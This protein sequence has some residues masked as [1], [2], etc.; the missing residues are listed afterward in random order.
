MVIMLSVNWFNKL[1]EIG[2]RETIIYLQINYRQRV[3]YTKK[4]ASVNNRGYVMT[5]R[6]RGRGALFDTNY[7]N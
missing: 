1:T 7:T 3:L 4:I 5:S 2:I 6:G